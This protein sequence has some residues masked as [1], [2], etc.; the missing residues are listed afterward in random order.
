MSVEES[1]RARFNWL[2]DFA[3]GPTALV[4]R[5]TGQRVPYSRPIREEF[6]AWC[7]YFFAILG[8]SRRIKRDFTMAFA[9]DPGRPWYLVW[10]AVQLAG[11]RIVAAAHA[12]V[13]MHF[14]DATF[15]P[16]PPPPTKA[17]ARLIN[18]GCT[19]VSK[20]RVAQAFED[21]FGY[22]L[23][24][25]PRDH[26]GLAVEKSERNGAHD[27]RVVTCPARPAPG[28]TYQRL[29]DNRTASG[30]LV[31][32][33]RCPTVGGRPVCV[34]IKRRRVTERFANSN[35]EVEL[36]AP[37]Q[38]F[39]SDELARIAGT[40][41]RLGLDWGGLDVLRDRTEGRLYIVDANKTDMGPP[42]ALPLAAKLDATRKLAHAFRRFAGLPE[43]PRFF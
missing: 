20:S 29:I 1:E 9:P 23:G 37:E 38:V 2:G 43:Q 10:P 6:F 15:S 30:D 14:D 12:D 27:G 13:V 31:E 39:T 5:K 18:F 11:A 3:I 17:G 41:Q 42:T 4:Y 22:G 28:K 32:D 33:L 8:E 34:F 40:A 36:A 24:L 16:N 19:D 35:V 25:D 21:A 26:S 7:R